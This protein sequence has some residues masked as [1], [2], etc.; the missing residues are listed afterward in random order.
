MDNLRDIL[1]QS[2][3]LKSIEELTTE[4]EANFETL[5]SIVIIWETEEGPL[6]HRCYGTY[7]QMIGALAR[8]KHIIERD[9]VVE[10][11]AHKRDMDENTGS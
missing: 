10:T 1:N 7:T 4:V 8:A 6:H 3:V 2:D 11:R 9:S 5:T